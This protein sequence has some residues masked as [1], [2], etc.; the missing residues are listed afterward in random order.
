[1]KPAKIIIFSAPSG[2]GKGTIIR[3]MMETFSELSFSVSATS[4]KPREGE[5]DGVEYYFLSQEE[6]K[7]RV[8][9]G[10][11]VEWEEYSGN[12]Y[13]TLKK[14]I[15]RMA[16]AGKVPVFEV[17]VR[18]ATNLKSAFGEHALWVFIKA[19]LDIIK[20]RLLA[21]GTDTAEAIDL[22][23]KTAAEEMTYESKADAVVENID[24][25]RALEDTRTV[26][27]TFLSK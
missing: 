10:E 17:E 2:A 13:G 21:R 9:R 16:E 8:D 27:S 12:Y 20:E 19:P 25:S 1:M 26:I 6:F 7:S 18:G 14:E 3:K 11:F 24:L 15:E 23:I 22:R 5:K 4:R